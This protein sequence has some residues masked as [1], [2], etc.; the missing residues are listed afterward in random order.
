MK[1][2]YDCSKNISRIFLE[3]SMIILENILKTF[4]NIPAIF[5]DYSVIFL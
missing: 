2:T 1:I 5:I 4:M 3:H